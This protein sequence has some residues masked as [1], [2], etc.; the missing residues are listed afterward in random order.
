MTAATATA[1]KLKV[2][3]TGQSSVGWHRHGTVL[4]CPQKYAYAYVENARRSSPKAAPFLG[5]L[6]HQGLAHYYLHVG[7][8]QRGKA[9]GSYARW[10]QAISEHATHSDEGLL[11]PA[12]EREALATKALAIVKS[13][14]QH[15]GELDSGKLEIVKVEHEIKVDIDGELYT[16][17]ADLI[18]Q[19]KRDGKIYTWDHKTAGGF[20]LSY[21]AQQ[22][23]LSGQI[24]GLRYLGERVYGEQFG[25]VLL[26]MIGTKRPG[27]F[28]RVPAAAAPDSQKAWLG[29]LRYARARIAAFKGLAVSSYPRALNPTVCYAYGGC[30]HYDRC[31][32]GAEET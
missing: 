3:N 24:L 6:I 22:Y 27:D 16:Q 15:Y 8:M 12:P 13:Y 25:G 18:V 28:E 29:T 23:T 7:L 5:T 31:R 11:F 4:E 14:I 17:R 32:W 26:N 19:S 10:D 20:G 30:D 21:G 2:L 1:T 9:H